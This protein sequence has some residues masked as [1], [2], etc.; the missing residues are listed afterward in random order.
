MWQDLQYEKSLYY[1]D[2]L[3]AREKTVLQIRLC[4]S[5]LRLQVRK[6]WQRLTHI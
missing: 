4:W 2:V 1:W 3:T 5:I 6:T